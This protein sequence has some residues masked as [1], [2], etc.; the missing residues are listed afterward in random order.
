MLTLDLKTPKSYSSKCVNFVGL[1]NPQLGSDPLETRQDSRY[2][3]SRSAQLIASEFYFYPFFLKSHKWGNPFM[4]YLCLHILT[5]QDDI[6]WDQTLTPNIISEPSAKNQTR[7]EFFYLAN[8][9]RLRREGKRRAREGG[10]KGEAGPR[11]GHKTKT[12]LKVN[13]I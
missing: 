9:G 5:N 7:Y 6:W 3:H 13:F 12:E 1:P 4:D 2:R 10:G 11:C 8:D